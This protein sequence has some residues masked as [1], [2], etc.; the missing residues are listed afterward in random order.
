MLQEHTHTRGQQYS[1]GRDHKRQVRVLS[2]GHREDVA[3]VFHSTPKNRKGTQPGRT[4]FCRTAVPQP[5]ARVLYLKTDMEIASV[6]LSWFQTDIMEIPP[7]RPYE[8][9][10]IERFRTAQRRLRDLASEV[11][12]KPTRS[13]PGDLAS[14]A[15]TRMVSVMLLAGALALALSKFVNS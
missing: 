15:L 2:P 8:K 6:L 12:L 10:D 9:A 4:G 11:D 3:L 14:S 7:Q 1:D 5:W 13:R